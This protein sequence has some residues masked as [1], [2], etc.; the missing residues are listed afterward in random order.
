MSLATRIKQAL[1]PRRCFPL[2]GSPAGLFF[3]I[4]S[5]S[6]FVGRY[7]AVL[8]MQRPEKRQGSRYPKIECRWKS[9]LKPAAEIQ[10]PGRAACQNSSKSENNLNPG[11][12]DL[13]PGPGLLFD[14]GVVSR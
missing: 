4:A 3:D 6:G 11:S 1:K 12:V 13:Q 7:P 14:N 5:D 2:Q 9:C 8:K 10:L